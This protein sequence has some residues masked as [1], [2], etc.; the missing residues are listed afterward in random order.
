MKIDSSTE[1]EGKNP[2]R[3]QKAENRKVRDKGNLG[4]EEALKEK[5]AKNAP[6]I[7]VIP[8]GQPAPVEPAKAQRKPPGSYNKEFFAKLRLQHPPKPR[9]YGGP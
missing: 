1:Y 2:I 6:V 9:N 3:A 7:N 5:R 4:K 8:V